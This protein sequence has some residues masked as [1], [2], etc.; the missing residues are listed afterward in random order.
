MSSTTEV[1]EAIVW[2]VEYEQKHFNDVGIRI[3][4]PK[5]AAETMVVLSLLNLAL[6]VGLLVY[7]WKI[8]SATQVVATT[9]S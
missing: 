4:D 1:P 9:D 7:S 8:A 3:A 6:D 5:G 2:C